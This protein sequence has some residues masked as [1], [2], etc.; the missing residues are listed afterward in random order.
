MYFSKYLLELALHWMH[1][2]G[3]YKVQLEQD[4]KWVT[5]MWDMFS[6]V[7]NMLK[8]QLV[9]VMLRFLPSEWKRALP[10]L[11]IELLLVP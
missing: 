10:D 1:K 5:G 2:S 7:Q 4:S 3:L 9:S 6:Q 11:P 8:S